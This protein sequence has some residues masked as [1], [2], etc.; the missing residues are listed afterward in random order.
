ML[1]TVQQVAT[2]AGFQVHAQLERLIGIIDHPV[3]MPD[4]LDHRQQVRDKDDEKHRAEG[5]HAQRQADIAAQELTKTLLV[6]RRRRSHGK[7]LGG[8]LKTMEFARK[9]AAG[10]IFS[11][12]SKA[13]VPRRSTL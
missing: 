7:G 13:Q 3:G 1:V 8:Q 4:P 12:E 2:H 6:N 10:S 5:A 9:K 11:D